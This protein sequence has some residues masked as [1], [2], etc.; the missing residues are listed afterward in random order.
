[1]RI[2]T[3]YEERTRPAR[4][5][6]PERHSNK[7]KRVSREHFSGSTLVSARLTSIV[8]WVVFHSRSL[9]NRDR[10]RTVLRRNHQAARNRSDAALKDAG[11]GVKDDRL[12]AFAPQKSLQPRNKNDVIGSKYFVHRP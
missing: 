3:T 8:A 1:M 4:A 11:V 12:D 5:P 2:A 9:E 10:T 6:S 7:F